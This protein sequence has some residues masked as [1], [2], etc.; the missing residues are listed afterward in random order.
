VNVFITQDPTFNVQLEAGKNIA[1]LIETDVTDGTLHIKNNNRCN[2]TRSYDKPLNVY[3]KMPIIKFITSNG[4]GNIKSL[5]TITTD[6]IDIQTESSGN[7][8]L[9]MNNSKVISHMHGAGDLTLHGTTGVH[10]SDIG[11][12]A[13]LRCQD[14]NTHYTTV[15][16][17]TTGECYVNTSNV[18]ICSIDDVG[19]V[20]CYG[21]PTSVQ[22]NQRG[23]GQLY[24]K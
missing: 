23:A 11:G 14:L 24:L 13:F 19:D 15:H 21:S 7:I 20:F 8:E 6:S 17:Y 9:T 5:N 16:T 22:K 2:W 18:F 1:P 12:T 4:T 10:Y 3:I